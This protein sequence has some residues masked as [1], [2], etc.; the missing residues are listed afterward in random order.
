MPKLI[1]IYNLT[2]PPLESMEENL[3]DLQAKKR[4]QRL[5][6]ALSI[7]ASANL[8]AI[9]GLVTFVALALRH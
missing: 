2:A 7:L 9:C 3:P 5:A 6:L 1:R 4:N 8:F